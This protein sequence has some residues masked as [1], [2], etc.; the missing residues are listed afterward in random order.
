MRTCVKIHLVFDIMTDDHKPQVHN[1]A[2]NE[3]NKNDRFHTE[4]SHICPRTESSLHTREGFLDP[5]LQLPVVI[6]REN[7]DTYFSFSQWHF[8]KLSPTFFFLLLEQ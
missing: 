5:L 1:P 8:Q 3:G 7:S 6:N 4:P 2:S